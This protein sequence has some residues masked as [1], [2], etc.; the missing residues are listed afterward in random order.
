MF[1]FIFVWFYFCRPCTYA[2]TYMHAVRLF[3]LRVVLGCFRNVL[4]TGPTKIKPVKNKTEH[5][6][7]VPQMSFGS[8]NEVKIKRLAKWQK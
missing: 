7:S 2:M 5:D 4:G 6:F 8:G 3:V 1:G